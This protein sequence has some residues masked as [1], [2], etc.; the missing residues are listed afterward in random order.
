MQVEENGISRFE[1]AKREIIKLASST[2][3]ND[4]FTVIFLGERS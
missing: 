1:L 4:M 3:P 2:T